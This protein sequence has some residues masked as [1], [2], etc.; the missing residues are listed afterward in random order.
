[1]PPAAAARGP[2]LRAWAS[3]LAGMWRVFAAHWPLL[4][5][6]GLLL[7]VPIGLLET[8]DLSVREAVDER[9]GD[10]LADSLEVLAVGAL[11]AVGSVL[12]EVVFAGV[13]TAAF[14]VEHGHR[15]SL[16]GLAGEL[17]VGR[18]VLADLVFVLVVVAGLLALVVPGLVFLVWFALLGPVIEVERVGLLRAFRRSREVV[19]GRPWLVAAIVIPLSLLEET[20]ASLAHL[21]AVEALGENFASEWAAG[22]LTE[23]LTSLPLALAA[24]VLYF[25]LSGARRSSPGTRP[26]A[27]PRSRPA[28]S[29]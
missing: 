23:L 22:T 28:A 13:V 2:F 11:H 18:L 24:V 5:L 16:R 3:V 6:A 9:G 29:P 7:F 27:S 21:A 26:P 17:S 12:G 4:L 8:V 15:A 25:E 19:R 14:M 10:G 20:L 1:M